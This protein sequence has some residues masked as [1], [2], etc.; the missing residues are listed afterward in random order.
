MGYT[1][2]NSLHKRKMG[3]LCGNQE[4]FEWEDTNLITLLKGNLPELRNT[5]NNT[6]VS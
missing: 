4:H 1:E 5:S 3:A 6:E 2:L